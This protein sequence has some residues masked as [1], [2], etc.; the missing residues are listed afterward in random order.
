MLLLTWTPPV[1]NLKARIYRNSVDT[2][3]VL[4]RDSVYAGKAQYVS[5]RDFDFLSDAQAFAL[6]ETG[7]EGRVSL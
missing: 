2:W 6:K 5:Q 4:I 1:R 3:T 7:S